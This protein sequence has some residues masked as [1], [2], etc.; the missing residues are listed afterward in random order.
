MYLDSCILSYALEGKPELRAA[1][2]SR[3]GEET[4][5]GEAEFFVSDL[6]RLECR[7]GP[8]KQGDESLLAL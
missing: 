3:I 4:K 6:T 7:V 2:R 1:V 5:R 8:L